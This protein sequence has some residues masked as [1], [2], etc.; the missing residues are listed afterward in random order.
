M[1]SLPVCIIFT[2]ICS[3][4]CSSSKPIA[5][6]TIPVA[7]V[8]TASSSN[9]SVP[10]ATDFSEQSAW[11]LGYIIP[12]RLAQPPYSEWYLRGY[13]DYQYN[14]DVL[15]KLSMINVSDLSIKIVLGTWC[16][17]SRREVP[18]FMKILDAWKFPLTNVQFIGVDH[19]RQSPVA[20]YGSLNI[21]RV[22][23][24]IIYKNIIEVGRIIEN[25]TTSL[26]L[27]IV[28]ILAGRN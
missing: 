4:S 10:R 5:E 14:S 25:P 16:S 18:R 3:Y 1:K 2:V 9:E 27:D 19:A 7:N 15:K 13:N 21:Q 17:D 24:F 20:E 23:T 8:H 12:G 6:K 11:L 28:N 22:P 26:E